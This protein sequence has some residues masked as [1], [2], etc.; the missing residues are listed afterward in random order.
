MYLRVGFSRAK[1][2]AQTCMKYLISLV[3]KSFFSVFRNHLRKRRERNIVME[4]DDD[5]GGGGVSLLQ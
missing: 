3:S 5:E 4:E 1:S 2:T